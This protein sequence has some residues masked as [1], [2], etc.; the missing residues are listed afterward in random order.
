[1]IKQQTLHRFLQINL[2]VPFALFGLLW[3]C[4][5]TQFY[6]SAL[7]ETAEYYVFEDAY[8]F[9]EIP[10]RIKTSFRIVS[11]E[12]ED[13]PPE[14]Q[15]RF[16]NLA[17]PIDEV[18]YLSTQGHDVYYLK[19]HP[20]KGLDAVFVLHQFAK[21]DSQDIRPLL[22][23]IMLISLLCFALWL[24]SVIQRVRA[25][26][27]QFTQNIQQGQ[28]NAL[29]KFEEFQSAQNITLAAL[30]SQKQQIEQQKAFASFLSHEVRHPITKLGHQL[31]QFD[32]MDELSIET[33]KQID[34][35]KTTQKE[36][37]QLSNTI[38]NLLD[39]HAPDE[40]TSC[41]DLVIELFNWGNSTPF[42]CQIDTQFEQFPVSLNTEDF[43]LLLNQ[44][45]TNMQRYG[46][47]SLRV[48]L[49][50]NELVFENDIAS[51]RVTSQGFGVGLF[52]VHAVARKMGWRVE[53]TTVGECFRLILNFK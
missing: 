39:V 22:L 9:V 42:P 10:T 52:I 6:W 48:R 7:D 18:Q 53:S 8:Q 37:V 49:N 21:A 15:K 13:F 51:G 4:I 17:M 19:H 12:V 25:P 34:A 23:V 38:L 35:L 29:V 41:S 46:S 30:A 31:A 14:I 3:L 44:V 47:G 1:M 20:S 33:L 28:E 27:A 5:A 16:K 24:L 36:T 43:A 45:N 50:T 26:L 40:K 2:L 32:H 11:D